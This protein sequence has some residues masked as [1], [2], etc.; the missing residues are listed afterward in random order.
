MGRPHRLRMGREPTEKQDTSA[1][2]KRT[3]TGLAQARVALSILLFDL[4]LRTH[5]IAIRLD[6]RR[7]LQ[8]H[9]HGG[10]DRLDL[11]RRGV[12]GND[13]YRQRPD[14]AGSARQ[15]WRKETETAA[16]G[17]RL[18]ASQGQRCV[19]LGGVNG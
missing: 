1:R 2:R 6:V 9:G 12:E 13:G 18:M 10:L 15:L 19:E 5:Q 14:L 8:G 7:Q 16:N 11:I 4:P 3:D 17:R